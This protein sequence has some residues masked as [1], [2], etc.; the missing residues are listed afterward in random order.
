MKGKIFFFALGALALTACTSEEVMDDV[1]KKSNAIGF[2]NV[3][4]KLTKAGDMDNASL[5]Q[6]NV[7]GYYTMNPTDGVAIQVFK[8][9][10]VTRPEGGTWGYTNTQYWIPDAH[11]YFYAYSDG[12]SAL[13]APYGE[14]IM[15]MENGVTP[16]SRVLKINDYVADATHQCD[17]VYSSSEGDTDEG[18][19]FPNGIIAKATGNDMVTFHFKHLLTKVTAQ[20]TNKFPDGYTAEVTDVTF[21]NIFNQGDYDPR[22]EGGW[23]NQ[24]KVGDTPYVTLLAAGAKATAAAGASDKS[25][26]AYTIPYGYKTGEYVTLRFK[27]TLFNNGVQ[28]LQKELTGNFIPAWNSGYSYLYNVELSGSTTDL[29]AIVFTTAKDEAGNEVTDW[30]NGNGTIL[31]TTSNNGEGE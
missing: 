3:V 5:N 16:S 14:L 7:Y 31:L 29:G 30:T 1:A 8:D 11:Y 18:A 10:P 2:E 27:L 20:F 15:N 17:L 23:Q 12:G 26:S 4:N 19:S 9:V 22:V 21:E 13:E 6:F 28:V 25:G 24:S